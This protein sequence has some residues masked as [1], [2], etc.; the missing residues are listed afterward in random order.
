MGGMSERPGPFLFLVQSNWLFGD[1]GLTDPSHGG[2]RLRKSSILYRT[3][4]SEVGGLRVSLSL[5]KK[6]KKKN[7][8]I[9]RKKDMVP[10]PIELASLL[11][12]SKGSI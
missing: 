4:P 6:K 11:S 10:F 5:I 3:F 2:E 12:R 7:N 8:N 1:V 9:I